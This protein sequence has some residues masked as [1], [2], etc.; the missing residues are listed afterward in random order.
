MKKIICYVLFLAVCNQSLSQ[1]L[2][3]TKW[4]FKTGDDVSWARIEHD[5]SDWRDIVS[6]QYWEELGV[7]NY[8]GFAWYRLGVLIPSSLKK[9]AEK[10]GGFLLDLGAID[11]VDYT[12]FNGKL[13]G[14]TGEIPPNLKTAYADLR[15]YQISSSSILWDKINVIAVRVYDAIGNGGMYS[16][17]TSFGVKGVADNFKIEAFFTNQNQ[18]FSSSS[19][20]AFNFRMTSKNKENV[21]GKFKLLVYSDFKDSITSLEKLV[22]IQKD[23]ITTIP[24]VLKNL[25]PGFYN[26]AAYFESETVNK[27]ITFSFGVQPEKIISPVDSKPDFEAYWNRAKKELEAVAPQYKLIKIDSLSKGKKDVYIVEM[28]SLGNVLIRGWYAVPKKAGKYPAILRL[29]GYSGYITLDGAYS[30]DDMVILALNVRGHGFSK[31]NINPG[32]PGFLQ[33]FVNDKE[34]YV[35]RGAYMDARRGLDFLFSRPEVDQAKVATEGG[36]QGGALSIAT[37]ALNNDRVSLCMPDVPF[38]S[39]FPDYFK[40]ASWPAG[41]FYEYVQRNP[42]V[43]WE[44]VYE[45][46]SYIDIKNLASYIKCPTLMGVGLVDDICPP[47]INFAAYNQIQ[48]AKEY[49]VYPKN[50]HG[51][52]AEHGAIKYQ[53]LKKQWG[54]K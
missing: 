12:Y 42:Q 41:E 47:H 44:K 52:P 43:G 31:D 13:I 8:D 30:D 18:I 23:N 35:Y 48:S 51:L 22:T 7:A 29:Q 27:N 10:M 11:D 34:M 40:I 46:L 21:K 5:D 38:L 32:F 36:S 17:N 49:I 1:N 54:M 4:K 19:D 14:K 53:W 20:A 33:F 24:F 26:A 15:K 28:R 16:T 37:A 50:G 6:G 39:D 2:L 45:T 9:D 25:K 3:K